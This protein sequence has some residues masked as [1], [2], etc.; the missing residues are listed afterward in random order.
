VEKVIGNACM[1][2]SIK[3]TRL[4]VANGETIAESL[5]VSGEFQPL[6]TRMLAVGEETGRLEQTLTKVNEFYDREVPQTVKHS[7]SGAA[8]N[9]LC[10]SCGFLCPGGN[11]PSFI[12]GPESHREIR[13]CKPNHCGGEA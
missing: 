9:Y 3:N 10:R 5:R 13:G 7:P 6:V 8:D 12:P 2:Q 4:K 1:A 11:F